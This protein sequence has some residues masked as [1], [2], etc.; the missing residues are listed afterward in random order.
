MNYIWSQCKKNKQKKH[1][2]GLLAQE[3][4]PEAL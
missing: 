1:T 3:S 2:I 4:K